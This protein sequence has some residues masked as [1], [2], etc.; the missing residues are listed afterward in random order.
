MDTQNGHKHITHTPL[1]C[2][3]FMI[4]IAYICLATHTTN[5][6]NTKERMSYYDSLIHSELSKPAKPK[7]K[8]EEKDDTQKNSKPQKGKK[9]KKGKKS[10]KQSVTKKQNIQADSTIENESQIIDKIFLEDK[11]ATENHHSEFP[12]P[13]WYGK[14]FSDSRVR[15]HN[16]ATL[17]SLPD[18]I[19]IQLVKDS[20]DFCFPIKNIITSPY[21]W[22]ERWNRPHRGVDIALRTGDKIYCCF[23]GIVRIARPLGAY[24]N[25]VVVRHYNGLETI[26]GHLSKIYVKPKQKVTAGTVLGLGGSTG[27]S[28]GPHLHFEVRFQYEAF[29]PEWILDFKNYSLRTKKL[30]LD[31]TYFG[32]KKPKNKKE[33]AIYKADESIIKEEE[34]EST[35]PQIKYKEPRYHTA[36]KGDTWEK[37]SAK[38]KISVKRLKRLNSAKD[39]Y[40]K[41]GTQIRLN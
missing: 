21:G 37:L 41:P 1:I 8:I 28:T 11:S 18:E 25:L 40:I 29:D 31:K 38:Y 10:N 33:Q 19:R 7:K 27:R 16:H 4:F 30:Y 6:Q 5:A 14:D 35:T 17:D 24:G 36:K 13:I 12:S 22:R 9:G 32:I 34:V 39:D 15:K 23:D 20:N 2:K 3:I 26:Y